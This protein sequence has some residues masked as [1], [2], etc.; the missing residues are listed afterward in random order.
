M[1][2]IAQNYRSGELAVLDVPVP[3]TLPGG[4]LVRTPVLAHLHR[5]R[6][7]EDQREQALAGRQGAG[8][9]RPGQEGHA[10]GVPA[11]SA[12]PPTGRSTTGS[13][14]TRRSATRCAA[15]S[16]RWVPAWRSWPSGS[17]W[18]APGTATPSTPST[19]GCRGTCACRCPTRLPRSTPRS[20]PWAPSPCRATGSRRR[21]WGDRL[22]H[23]PRPGRAAAGAAPAGRRRQRGRPRP[24]DRAVPAGRAERRGRLPPT[25]PGQPR[26]GGGGARRPHRR[27]R[28][29]PRLPH[30]RWRHQPAG[31]ARRRAGPRPGPGRRHRQVPPRPALDRVLRQGAGRPLLA[32]VRPRPLRPDLRG[33]RGRLPDRLRPLDRAA[34]HGLLPRP[35]GRG[36]ARPRAPRLRRA[37]VRRCGRR[38]RADPA[39]GA[40]RRRPAVPLLGQRVAAAPRATPPSPS[41]GPPAGRPRRW[42]GWV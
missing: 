30:R 14:P 1:K 20:P 23:R 40:G 36:S 15:R 22:R 25:R 32:L 38:L 7:D 17:G 33:G 26:P 6:D 31:R 21:G 10:V 2:Q 11:G 37:A 29:R 13:T 39:R 9:A 5:H 28:S 4:V 24:V 19:T 8:A 42:S 41:T 18:P 34:Q 35:A 12:S 16:S 27:R 3:A